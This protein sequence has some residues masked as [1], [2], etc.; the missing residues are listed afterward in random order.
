MGSTLSERVRGADF[1]WLL[2]AALLYY[3]GA[4]FGMLV[5]AL[6]PGNITLLWLAS[7]VGLVMAMRFSW[8]ALPWI[9]L[10]SLAANFPE[11]IAVR[12]A[13]QSWPWL[14]G[15]VSALAD[16]VAP[17]LAASL[18]H[19]RLPDGLR[20]ARDIGPFGLYACLI[21]S[22]LGALAISSS[23]AGSALID[24]SQV[25]ELL[26]ALTVA[27]SLGILLVY[28][29]YQCWQDEARPRARE[30]V[31]MLFGL[32]LGLLLLERAFAGTGG[33]IHFLPAMLVLLVFRLSAA[34]VL[35][36][37]LGLM[38]ALLAL[39]ARAL[40][41][42]TIASLGESRF[43]LM[44]FAFS[45]SFIVLCLALHRRQLLEADQARE[46]WR[47]EALLDG[48][49]GLANR[50]AFMTVCADEV[51]RAQH[52][53][54]PLVLALLDLDHFKS[55]ND[56]FGHPAGDE[57]LRETARLLRGT[58]LAA[59]IGGEEFALLLP[60]QTLGEAS[61]ALERIRESVELLRPELDGQTLSLTVSIGVAEVRADRVAT[62]EAL[63]KLADQRLYMA[64]QAGRNRVCSGA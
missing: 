53:G 39:A 55:V 38:V 1:G 18:L 2:G 34:Q 62:P 45:T 19:W 48:L 30:L 32:L 10:A 15:L 42:F 37:L 59:R 41:P 7:G 33:L 8:R 40:G 9:G 31:W 50:R 58:D 28:P 14:A 24:W 54:R 52:N 51:Q 25:P 43:M 21:P 47:H 3:L 16:G 46:H 36:V 13:D 61:S 35:L 17:C 11:L 27:D 6:Q 23:L 57:V 26:R 4:R 20:V 60:G 22:A 56:R 64:K 44:A 12:G 49:T 5:F 63:F 29:L